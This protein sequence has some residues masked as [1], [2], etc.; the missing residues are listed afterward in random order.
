VFDALKTIPFQYQFLKPHKMKLFLKIGGLLIGLL[1]LGYAYIQFAPSKSF[2]LPYSEFELST[3]STVLE[4]GKYLVYGPARCSE[5]HTQETEGAVAFVKKE[6]L[7]PLA[8]G[9]V[10]HTPIGEIYA[11]NI[12]SDNETGI[13]KLSPGAIARTLRHAVNSQ[14]HVMVPFMKYTHLSEADMVAIISFLKAQAPVSNPVPKSDYNLMG[15]MALKFF[16]K[17]HKKTKPIIKDIKPSLD[18]DYGAYLTHEV[19]GCGSC[20]TTFNMDKMEYDGVPLAG[21]GDFVGKEHIF[22]PPN[23]TPDPKTGHITNWTEAQFVSRFRAGKVFKDSPMP[24]ENFGLMKDDDLKAVY[25]YLQSLPPH[26]NDM[27]LVVRAIAEEEE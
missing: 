27:G 24:W 7:S 19:T 15:N 4:R 10:F 12:T 17:P 11:K 14:G 20:H 2:D 8:G 5:C 22:R 21:G 1:L 6:G 23:L 26:E 25:R 16:L 13:G 3:D 18:L 9:H